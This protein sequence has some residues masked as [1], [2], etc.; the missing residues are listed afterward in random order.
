VKEACIVLGPENA[1]A[2][3]A[4][5]EDRLIGAGGEEDV[6]TEAAAVGGRPCR[7]FLHLDYLDA[8]GGWGRGKTRRVDRSTSAMAFQVSPDAVERLS[9]ET[10]LAIDYLDRGYGAWRVQLAS[11]E[12][13]MAWVANSDRWRQARFRV[14]PNAVAAGPLVIRAPFPMFLSRLAL[15]PPTGAAT[16]SAEVTRELLNG[17]RPQMQFAVGNMGSILPTQD[18]SDMSAMR[19]WLPILQG[20]G[21]TSIQSYVRWSLIEPEPGRFDWRFYD[22][23]VERLQAAGMRWVVFIMI[24]Q[25]YATPAWFRESDRSVYVRCLE[26]DEDSRVQSIW[27]PHL[28]EQVDRFM[29]LVADRYHHGDL[30][31]SLMLGPSGD[32]GETTFNAVYIQS[33][34]HTHLGYWCGDRG[35]VADLR[36]Y[37][38]SSYGTLDR[39]NRA[40]GTSHA[41]WEEVTPFLRD[42]A[43]SPRAWLDLNEW[44]AGS[45]TEFSGRWAEITRRHFPGPDIYFAA[46][47]SGDP[48]HGGNWSAQA[49]AAAPY[50]VG[51]RVTNE[52]SDFAFNFVYTRWEATACKHYGVPFG[53][54]PWGGDMSGVGNLARMYNAI[55]S[56]ASHFWIYSGHVR[57]PECIEAVR[58]FREELRPERAVVDVATL[59]PWTDFIQT[60]ERAFSEGKPRSIFWPQAE[61][62]RDITDYDLLDE[63]L[64]RD[65]ALDSYR[66]LVVLQGQTV[67]GDCLDAIG[68]WIAAGGALITHDFGPVQTT[69]GDAAPWEWLWEGA[70]PAVIGGTA[71]QLARHGK[72]AAL[73]LTGSANRRGETG[74]HKDHPAAAP[75]FLQLVAAVLRNPAGVGLS[76]P[77]RIEPDGVADGVYAAL[78]PGAVVYLNTGPEAVEKRIERPAGALAATVPGYAIL[79]VPLD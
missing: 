53:N 31:E 69:D 47:G 48:V 46:G 15:R 64:L 44:Y 68:R 57:T 13:H 72:G 54:E 22:E 60:D 73:R 43:P 27:N 41:R 40:W 4:L 66:F 16:T 63:I 38:E 1:S 59:Y 33:A 55:T 29:G 14:S 67:P 77:P 34:Y 62:L 26:H 45:M 79:R 10:E 76:G 5:I 58:R 23:V 78:V 8:E 20:L 61:E 12:E 70:E 37:L 11:G 24:G 6:R 75:E 65:G 36:R 51:H 7:R 18:A 28:L 25:E 42:R 30:I 52:G 71:A 49:K 50:Q 35:A 2:G 21:A 32:F 19:E 74:D 17:Y 39:L 9:G 56:N 3:I